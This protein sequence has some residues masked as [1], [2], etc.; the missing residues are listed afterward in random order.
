MYAQQTMDLV[1]SA[2]DRPK[3]LETAI[4]KKM[5]NTSVDELVFMNN[6][7]VLYNM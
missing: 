5:L 4:G 7:D 1:C 2:N 3:V 6:M